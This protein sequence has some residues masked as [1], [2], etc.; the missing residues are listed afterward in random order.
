MHTF[1][2]TPEY[3]APEVLNGKP[4]S[5]SVDWW[6]LG[7]VLYEM[8]YGLVS[9]AENASLFPPHHL[10]HYQLLGLFLL[11]PIASIFQ[12]KQGRDV[13]E[14][15]PRP[16]AAARWSDP[17]CPVTLAR[18]V[19]KTC[20]QALGREPWP[21]ECVVRSD[22]YQM[23]ENPEGLISVCVCVCS[24]RATGTFLFRAHRLGWPP[25]PEAQTPVHP[26]RGRNDSDPIADCCAS[27]CSC[28]APLQTGPCDVSYIDPEFTLQPVPDSVNERC[29]AG[30]VSEAFP[31][32][33]FVNPAEYVVSWDC[34]CFS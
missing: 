17:G 7:V 3:L 10:K 31:G 23:Q 26:Q 21:C 13:W 22:T 1:C 12:P 8:L 30:P 14:Y 11:H 18:T 27:V 16:P 29:R 15:P 6:G 5:P 24:G 19:G 2:G 34:V 25:G 28:V 4:Y 20:L 33:S 32:F 9:A